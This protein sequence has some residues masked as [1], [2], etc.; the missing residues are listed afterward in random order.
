MT[1]LLNIA[2][3]VLLLST[4]V[5]WAEKNSVQEMESRADAAPLGDRPPL[6]IDAAQQQ[7]STAIDGYKTGKSDAAHAAVDDVVR[8]A[9]KARDSA[10]QSGKKLKNTEI[11]VRKMADK[12]HDLQR[13]LDYADQA[14]VQAAAQK[15]ETMRND[16]LSY[17]F[18][19]GKQ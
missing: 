14:P 13:T 10:I 7:L 9:E 16:L 1:R 19:K 4:C 2:A 5:L 11:S 15:L 17:M 3:C 6:Y 12:L 18:S 8:L